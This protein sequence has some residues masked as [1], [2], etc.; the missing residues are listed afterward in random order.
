MPSNNCAKAGRQYPQS[1]IDNQ[2]ASNKSALA[3]EV[4]VCVGALKLER[5]QRHGMI[6][7]NKKVCFN[8]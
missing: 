5:S 2:Y 6:R 1:L 8:A 3:A 7:H 4:L